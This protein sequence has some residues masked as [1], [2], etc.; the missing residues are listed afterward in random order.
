MYRELLQN[1]NDAEA[2]NAEIHFTT[3]LTGN[4]RHVSQVVYRNDGH[5]FREPDWSRLRNIAEGNPDVSKVGAFGVGA[6]TMF[7]ICEEPL[8]ISG[9]TALAFSWRGDALWARSAPAPK[10]DPVWT[11]F[12]LPSRDPYP[13]PELVPF[14]QFLCASLTFTNSLRNIRL[15]IDE[16]NVL[17]IR[18]TIIEKPSVVTPP[19][20]SSWF[21]NDGMVTKS[22]NSIFTLGRSD[23]AVTQSVVEI[24]VDLEGHQHSVCARYMS[25]VANVRVPADML[26]RIER[27]TKKSPPPQVSVHIFIDAAARSIPSGNRAAEVTH[28]FSPNLGAGRVFIGFR[29]S[30]TTGLAAHLAGPL[31]PTVEREAI[32]L[33]DRALKIYNSDLLFVAGIL[34]RLTLEHAMGLVG[35]RWENTKEQRLAL[36]SKAMLETKKGKPEIAPPKPE[37]K[38]PDPP[39]SDGLFGF[40]RFMTSG[41]KR[42]AEAITSGDMGRADDED[43][44]NPPDPRPLSGEERDAIM[45]M[46]AFSPQQSTPD[47]TVG[48]VIASGFVTCMPKQSPPVLTMSGVVR[49]TDSR[50]PFRGIEAFVKKGVI[51]KVV[52]SNAE[53]FFKEVAGCRPLS[54]NDLVQELSTRTL[55]EDEFIRFVKWWVRFTRVQPETLPSTRQSLKDTL[56][57]TVEPEKDRDG[58]SESENRLLSLKDVPFF[59]G[60]ELSSGTLPMPPSVL[61][62]HIQNEITLRTLRDS[63]LSS[64]FSPLSFAT[65]AGYIVNHPILKDGH[66]QDSD[67]RLEVLA[68]LSKELSRRSG[69][70]R[71]RY[72]KWINESLAK[73]QCIPYDSPLELAV[74]TEH[75]SDMY[76][77]DAEIGIFE[78]LGSFKKVSVTLEK[79]GISKE[80]LIAIGARKAISIDFLLTNLDNLKWNDDPEPLVR[81]LR[82]ATLSNGDLEKLRESQYL[83]EAKDKSRTYSPTELHLPNEELKNF[84]FVKILQWSGA[85]LESS[86]NATFLKKLGCRVDPSLNRVL[87]YIAKDVKDDKTRLQCLEFVAH[88]LGPGGAYQNEYGSF[89][90]M[91]FLPAIRKD[92]LDSSPTRSEM[93]SP[94]T[95][96]S[97][98]DCLCLDFAVLDSK[99]VLG[100]GRM[101]GERFRCPLKP[102]TDMLIHQLTN[103]VSVAKRKTREDANPI[104]AIAISNVLEAF[105]VIFRYLS[106][107][108]AEMTAKEISTLKEVAFIPCHNGGRVD[109]F[110]PDEVYFKNS[111]DDVGTLLC[112]VIEFDP[113]LA[114]MG[115]RSE[116][117][118]KDLMN[119][120]VSG[121]LGVLS[122][123]GSEKYTSLLRRLSSYFDGSNITPTMRRSPFLIAYRLEGEDNETEESSNRVEQ[124][125]KKATARYSLAK[126]DDICIID[127]SFF[128]RLFPVLTAPQEVDLERFYESLGSEYISKRVQQNHLL[129]GEMMT[130]TEITQRLTKRLEERLPLLISP[131]ITTRRFRSDA[132]LLVAVDNV[133]VYEVTSVIA[134]YSLGGTT[135]RRDVSCCAKIGPKK[136]CLVYITAELDW[137]DVGTA[138][139]GLILARC[140]L[141]DAFFVGSILE[142]PLEQLRARGFPVDRILKSHS[143]VSGIEDQAA[144]DGRASAGMKGKPSGSVPAET[145]PHIP[146]AAARRPEKHETAQKLLPQGDDQ[147]NTEAEKDNSVGGYVKILKAMFPNCDDAYLKQELG[148]GPTLDTLQKVAG[149]LTEGG[150]PQASQSP[151]SPQSL[152]AP[153]SGDNS[154]HVE[155]GSGTVKENDEKGL[156]AGGNESG[157]KTES[158]GEPPL[159]ENQAGSSS[160]SFGDLKR[161]RDAGSSLFNRAFRSKNHK[162]RFDGSDAGSA[163][164]AMGLLNSL[165]A[166]SPTNNASL[167]ST[168]PPNDKQG[169]QGIESLLQNAV[170]SSKSVSTKGVS[171]TSGGLSQPIPDVSESVLNNSTNCDLS[172][173]HDLKPFLTKATRNGTRIFVTNAQVSSPIFIREHWRAVERFSM[174]L[175]KLC[176]VF[177]VNVSCV[178]IYHEAIDKVIAFNVNGALHFN[179]RYFVSLHD[180]NF[181]KGVQHAQ[182]CYAYWFTTMAHELA[183][184]IVHEHSRQHGFF[185]ESYITTY[186]PNLIRHVF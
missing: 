94:N 117:S 24:S 27:V 154:G 103:I 150:Y 178:A 180:G 80:F 93:Q 95:C 106:S 165:S 13:V 86:L 100:V 7:S 32:D 169:Q 41:V 120:L 62:L 139:G 57:F 177:N 69:P 46:R 92:P 182:S 72:E 21:A 60:D 125:E 26:R 175:H 44:L 119:I 149:K 76:L 181:D 111:N 173:W 61:P 48:A 107:R 17:T 59:R 130:N 164:G 28:A 2:Q 170:R 25:A 167:D 81:Y 38:N 8:V 5:P 144:G 65:W 156:L 55:P 56:R 75:P 135:K 183:H 124:I 138:I 146:M 63:A 71:A 163:G 131:K 118:P 29:T 162:G 84:P 37:V 42:I 3:A 132:A 121:P 23:S 148:K 137:F 70:D 171:G 113:F 147:R 36:E 53:N 4:V 18:K 39:K 99:V 11:T 58:S 174:V 151:Q 1:S 102:K 66:K 115:V 85:L 79:A 133:V 33:Q 47:Q 68:V 64:W 128:A 40:V 10:P 96:F 30:Q 20:A 67:V 15:I 51:R 14:A 49:A 161:V 73:R 35:A 160:S 159:A 166:Q 112:K 143:I 89:L 98:P 97:D 123:L 52:F 145:K 184:N 77:P 31:I 141:E 185:T 9:Q 110:K 122:K 78:G 155:A 114:A 90:N 152:Q 176:S 172:R 116:P 168:E 136:K 101:F 83:P 43:Y 87:N 126:A 104:D 19:R 158:E 105:P 34:M 140:Q 179:V 134:R 88:R 153:Q 142:A 12:V 186:L 54:T 50:L 109:W 91:R 129:R 82:T 22:P 45:L 127:N 108:T 157:S 16:A 6:Y 74:G